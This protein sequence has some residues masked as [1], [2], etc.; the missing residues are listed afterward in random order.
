[1]PL[2]IALL[3][4]DPDLVR[5]SQK[6]RF[7]SV[8]LVD[9]VLAADAA[10]RKGDME[11]GEMQSERNA[12]QKE[13]GKK[14]KA[15]EPCDDLV[16]KIA[17]YKTKIPEEEEKVKALE[18]ARNRLLA[19]IGN[20]VDDSVIV[21][22]DEEKDNEVV[23]LVGA[24]PKGDHLWHHHELLWM[25]GG[26]EPEAGSKV[27]GHRAYFL[28]DVGV[29]LNQALINYGIAFLRNR[30]N[31]YKILQPPYFMNKDVMAGVAQLEQFDE[32]LYHVK[33]DDEK[34]LIATSEQPICAFHKDEWLDIKGLPKR[35]AGVS[36]CFRKEAGS[37]GRDV[38]GIFRVHQFEKVEQ[39]MI[40]DGDIE[41]SR[42][43]Q[44]EMMDCAEDFYKSLGLSYHVVNIVSGELNNAAIKKFDLEAWFPGYGQ[45]RELVSCSNCTDY[46]SRSMNIRVGAKSEKKYVHMLNS[47]LCATTRTLSCIL[48]NY[49]TPH[50]VAVPEVLI[51]YM[52]GMTMMPFVREPKESGKPK[53]KKGKDKQA[54]AK[55]K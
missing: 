7:A 21:S 16:A 54:A 31:P 10:W 9:Q 34:Y 15:K 17:E 39:F 32:E 4:S 2:D 50:G 29:M 46:Q 20:L 6:K 11:L 36:T 35:Y 24:T 22:Q 45:Y 43:A 18:K 13:V 42:K 49:Q 28:T 23:K 26:Y 52:G 48:E 53:V 40:T 14:K 41:V 8:E 5:E 30:E 3:R 47:T 1:M 55:K 27:A 12:V 19:Q 38:W 51:P 33:G 37:S 44:E 25:I